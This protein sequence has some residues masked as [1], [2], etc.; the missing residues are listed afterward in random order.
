M[1]PS[2]PATLE[3]VAED[4]THIVRECMASLAEKDAS[5]FAVY[6]DN[7]RLEAVVDSVTEERNALSEKM[8]IAVD[9]LQRLEAGARELQKD[10]L[11]VQ[12]GMEDVV[13]ETLRLVDQCGV[14]PDHT[15]RLEAVKACGETGAASPLYRA[16]HLQDVALSLKLCCQFVHAAQHDTQLLEIEMEQAAVASQ[17]SHQAAL[18]ALLDTERRE[19]LILQEEA[20]F[21]LP[22]LFLLHQHGSLLRSAED[23]ERELSTL[24]SLHAEEK[25]TLEERH[26]L[27]AVYHEREVEGLREKV[28]KT[29]AQ[30]AR[31]EKEYSCLVLQCS[32]EQ[33]WRSLLE[34]RVGIL[35][36]RCC[37]AERQWRACGSQQLR[38]FSLRERTLQE[39]IKEL[40]G[41][42][43][44]LQETK[45]RQSSAIAR[46][47][48]LASSCAKQM[49]AATVKLERVTKEYENLKT[50]HYQLIQQEH[51]ARSRSEAA[52]AE[53]KERISALEER[54]AAQEQLTREAEVREAVWK[55]EKKTLQQRVET[56]TSTIEALQ[57][58]AAKAETIPLLLHQS[59]ERT[60]ALGHQL[61]V[62]A[63][64]AE[65]QAKAAEELVH[66]LEL[67]VRD[68]KQ[69]A[70]ASREQL[71]RERRR[72]DEEVAAAEGE[73]RVVK[74]MMDSLREEQKG[75]VRQLEMERRARHVLEKQQQ[76]EM[77][78]VKQ[79]MAKAEQAD[80]KAVD[81]CALQSERTSLTEKV[82]LLE[83]ACRKSASVIS[84]LRESVFV[85]R[86]LSSQLLSSIS[87]PKGARE[88]SLLDLT[89]PPCLII[90]Q[91]ILLRNVISRFV[92]SRTASI[93]SLIFGPRKYNTNAVLS[94]IDWMNFFAF[95]SC[96]FFLP[97]LDLCWMISPIFT[98]PPPT[99]FG[100]CSY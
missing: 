72:H 5:L 14:A 23:A 33:A 12:A 45:R 99:V 73:V 13:R 62:Q 86:Q 60:A 11:E 53:Q 57:P 89:P 87:S 61:K 34:E 64:A 75:Y 91:Q 9:T 79:I 47:E 68:A 38:S 31:L 6:E 95:P 37:H 81:I 27:E 41:T 10:Y 40:E 48:S 94:T 58:A 55:K 65:A 83:E 100:C 2:A 70:E 51:K 15:A 92:F 76:L 20:L 43:R 82:A 67:E 84:E 74:Q 30:H 24:L 77:G 4:V 36:T 80:Q 97:L 28:G 52:T 26:K 19:R 66:Q 7:V 16:S 93:L 1:R 59:E 32:R 21:P 49:E 46:Q 96:Y 3:E 17:L 29:E 90:F 50:K 39:K 85:E 88:L 98:I 42:Q 71:R 35:Q 78:V 18:E 22:L 8:S 54:L 56:L 69:E 44:Q 63:E 25:K